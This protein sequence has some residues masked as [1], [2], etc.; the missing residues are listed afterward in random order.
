MM[1]IGSTIDFKSDFTGAMLVVE[2]PNAQSSCGCG[3]SV[4][5]A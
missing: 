2:N 1:L 5:F 4:N 3:T